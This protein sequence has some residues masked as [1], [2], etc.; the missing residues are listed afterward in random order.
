MPDIS[1]I[2]K[3]K[4]Y[5]ISVLMYCSFSLKNI[6]SMSTSCNHQ[7]LPHTAVDQAVK[8]D[9]GCQPRQLA[10][11]D[12]GKADRQLLPQQ[13]PRRN[14]QHIGEGRHIG[15]V[16]KPDREHGHRQHGAGEEF[17]QRDSGPG[18]SQ[19]ARGEKA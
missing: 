9:K 18:D 10:Q 6:L 7:I 1:I 16:L 5:S 3:L 11:V 8:K 15:E 13:Q 17:I 4:V 12:H 2:Q 19:M 14:L